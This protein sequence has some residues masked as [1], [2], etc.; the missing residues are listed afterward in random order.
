MPPPG[1]REGIVRAQRDRTTAGTSRF[2]QA[3]QG[4][5][6]RIVRGVYR[7]DQRL[8]EM[9]LARDLGVSRPTIRMA[10]VRLE[11]E[12]LI[13]TRANR[14]ASVRSIGPAEA[15]RTL[16]LREV[17]D[18][19]AAALAAESATPDELDQM[20]AIVEEMA[21]LKEPDQLSAYSGLN[22]RLHALILKAARDDLL[23][24]QLSS[25]NYALVRYQYRTVLAPGRRDRS[26]AEH[27]AIVEAIRRRD[28]EAAEQAMRRHVSQVRT[29]LSKT[30]EAALCPGVPDARRSPADASYP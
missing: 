22:G 25:L 8:T 11:R 26:L 5:R 10:L 28:P 15:I 18:G 14:G 9:E 30:V 7:S 19:L 16:R 6:D 20:A 29:I 2:D 21:T 12:G 23:E 17:L 4:L 3:Y 24:R 13:V 27:R 1:W